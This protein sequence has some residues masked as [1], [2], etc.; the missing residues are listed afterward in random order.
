ME[1]L[2]TYYRTGLQRLEGWSQ[3]SCTLSSALCLTS[4]AF[5]VTALFWKYSSTSTT[6]TTSRA[7]T[8]KS[9]NQQ[10]R[11]T[12][13]TV[14]LSRESHI[15]TVST[16]FHQEY[17]PG[18]LQLVGKYDP[19]NEK[20][21]YDKRYYNEML[22]KLLIELDG[23]DITAL[24]TDDKLKLKNRR[25]TVIKEIQTHLQLLDTLPRN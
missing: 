18:L 15:D 20:N 23:I 9:R 25:K 19:K 10:Q 3:N 5:V 7:K 12:A 22:L 13:K 4:A 2:Q 6:T 11:M 17:K 24:P 21:S 14:P 8:K 1:Q 16:R